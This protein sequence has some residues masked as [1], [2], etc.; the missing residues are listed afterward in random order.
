ML[1]TQ[2]PP[3]GLKILWDSFLLVPVCSLPYKTSSSSSVLHHPC[4]EGTSV[5][6]PSLTPAHNSHRGCFSLPIPKS[7]A[8]N[9]QNLAVS[10][11]PGSVL[12]AG[13]AVG[14]A[15][16]GCCGASSD[17]EAGAAPHR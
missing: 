11:F 12:G 17:G 16:Q 14:V 5:Q 4:L 6:L 9:S 7:T 2:I 15:A 10:L 13:S 1:G 8:Q 3:A